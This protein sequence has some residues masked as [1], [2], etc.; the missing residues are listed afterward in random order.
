[1][2]SYLRLI[3]L[4]HFS[5]S[6]CTKQTQLKLFT[7]YFYSTTSLFSLF[8]LSL[9]FSCNV[10][11]CHKDLEEESLDAE[12]RRPDGTLVFTH[13]TEFTSRLQARLTEKVS[14]NT[15]L[16]CV[17]F[18][19][20]VLQH[21]LPARSRLL[22]FFV[23]SASNLMI[24]HTSFP[25]ARSRAEAVVRAAAAAEQLQ[26]LE[27]Q[28]EDSAED[29]GPVGTGRVY[30]RAEGM[31]VCVCVCVCTYIYM[32]V[33]VLCVCVCECVCYI[34]FQSHFLMTIMP[35]TWHSSATSFLLST[36]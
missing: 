7:P 2:L 4:L 26:Q 16:I 20:C 30:G 36:Y 18:V 9:L 5:L 13:T 6:Y 34:G 3:I 21:Y 11:T 12:G 19:I 31:C 22:S 33:Y 10:R 14:K 29:L 32:C 27:I 24:L 8:S 28:M 23:E 17:K 25:K 35:R 1:L 15:I